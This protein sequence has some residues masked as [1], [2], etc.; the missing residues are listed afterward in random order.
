M[1]ITWY[2]DPQQILLGNADIPARSLDY[3]LSGVF[4]YGNEVSYSQAIVV[5]QDP[6]EDLTLVEREEEFILDGRQTSWILSTTITD[7]ILDIRSQ[8]YVLPA[9]EN[10]IGV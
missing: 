7:F 5:T 10:I 9:I 8:A 6:I 3:L 4:V 2:G 1:I